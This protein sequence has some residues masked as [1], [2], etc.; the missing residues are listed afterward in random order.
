MGDL[1]TLSCL[2]LYELG[3]SEEWSFCLDTLTEGLIVEAFGT[4]EA[5]TMD[6]LAFD[7][8]IGMVGAHAVHYASEPAA[9]EAAAFEL[10]PLDIMAGEG[11]VDVLVV[12]R[13]EEDGVS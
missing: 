5:P 7:E 1:G 2:L 8:V 11:P 10:R 3:V 12:F 13:T 9:D 4:V 6:P